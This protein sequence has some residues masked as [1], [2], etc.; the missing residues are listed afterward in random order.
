ML[1][2]RMTNE[3]TLFVENF[4]KRDLHDF[5]KK[6]TKCQPSAIFVALK[7]AYL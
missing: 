3:K 5:F 2:K 7:N 6:A 1:L 4:E